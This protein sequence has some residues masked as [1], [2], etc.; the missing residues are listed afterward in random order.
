M[1]G[2][3]RFTGN[4][5]SGEEAV[6]AWIVA[7]LGARSLGFVESEG[8]DG[9]GV[10]LAEG[11]RDGRVLVRLAHAL[12]RKRTRGFAEVRISRDMFSF[13]PHRPI[14][15]VPWGCRCTCSV[16]FMTS[17][18]QCSVFITGGMRDSSAGFFFPGVFVL[19]A[20]SMST[21]GMSS[22][23]QVELRKLE[24]LVTIVR[25]LA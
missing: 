13:F 20:I 16:R 24:S 21:C 17:S 25:R 14:S 12:D 4:R 10:R 5:V 2:S 22:V 6:K 8:A 19:F 23:R 11:L 1:N 9:G 15:S 3:K 7:V 18:Y